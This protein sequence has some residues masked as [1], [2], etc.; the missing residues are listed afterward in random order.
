MALTPPRPFY[1]LARFLIGM[2]FAMQAPAHQLSASVVGYISTRQCCDVSA[3]AYIMNGLYGATPS[4][5][6]EPVNNF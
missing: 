4:S 3:I 5:T 1:G 6:S 2:L